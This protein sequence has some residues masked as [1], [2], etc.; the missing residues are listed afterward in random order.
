MLP[1]APDLIRFRD[2]RVADREE[3]E[4]LMRA[5]VLNFDLKG[6]RIRGYFSHS[7]ALDLVRAVLYAQTSD[8]TG[9]YLADNVQVRAP[10]HIEAAARTG[11]GRVRQ[12]RFGWL[13]LY[14][15]NQIKPYEK[16][17]S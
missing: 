14:L 10:G 12:C 1:G 8:L 4:L 2:P 13:Q 7:F 9:T 16:Q 15:S 17:Q 3:E 11:A 6:K 5:R